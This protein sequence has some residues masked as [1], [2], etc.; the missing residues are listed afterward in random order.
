MLRASVGRL[1]GRCSSSCGRCWAARGLS[2]ASLEPFANATSA[3]YI[4]GM[5][6][7]WQR[8]PDSVHAVCAYVCVFVCVC[9]RARVRRRGR[10]SY[11][12][13]VP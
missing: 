3:A 10:W 13:V 9:V 12:G 11:I 6:E 4:E 7:A 5:F 1:R 2:S 8:D